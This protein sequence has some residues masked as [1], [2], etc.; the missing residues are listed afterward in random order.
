MP[1]ETVDLL[2]SAIVLRGDRR[3]PIEKGAHGARARLRVEPMTGEE[4]IRPLATLPRIRKALEGT[5]MA[6]QQAFRRHPVRRSHIAAIT[7]AVGLDP[8]R[9]LAPLGEDEIDR[10]TIHALERQLGTDGA[11][12]ARPGPIARLDPGPSEALVVEDAELHHPLDGTL[13]ELGSIAG[14]HEAAPNLVD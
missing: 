9:R 10:C 8:D 3:A 11:F 7:G 12:P 4:R 13:D 6:R 1:R 2:G 5:A 14:L